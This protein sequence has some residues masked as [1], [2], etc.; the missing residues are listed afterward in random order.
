MLLF[1][2]IFNKIDLTSIITSNSFTFIRY[3]L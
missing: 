2:I 3:C 1:H